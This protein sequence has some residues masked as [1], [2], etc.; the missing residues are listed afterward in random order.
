MVIGD[1]SRWS[2]RRD[3]VS[4]ILQVIRSHGGER[5]GVSNMLGIPPPLLIAII[6][7]RSKVK[8]TA[9]PRRAPSPPHARSPR[10]T[11]ISRSACGVI[12]PLETVRRFLSDILPPEEIVHR[13]IQRRRRISSSECRR[14]SGRRRSAICVCI[15]SVRVCD[16]AFCLIRAIFEY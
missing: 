11:C 16:I 4:G 12:H 1:A 14:S 2:S 6:S 15:R 10:A 9:P 5:E 7:H 13:N 8:P 3:G